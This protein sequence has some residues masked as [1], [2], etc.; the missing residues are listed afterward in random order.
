MCML[1]SFCIENH[2]DQ[3]Q[4]KFKVYIQV[5]IYVPSLFSNFV[6]SNLGLLHIA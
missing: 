1:Q 2:S 6:I 3:F 4:M 5:Y